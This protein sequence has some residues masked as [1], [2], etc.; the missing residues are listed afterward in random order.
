M[1]AVLAPAQPAGAA[2][3][4]LKASVV[5]DAATDTVTASIVGDAFTEGS[6]VTVHFD[7]IAGTYVSA[8]TQGHIPEKNTRVTKQATVSGGSLSVIGYQRAWPSASYRFYTE[9]VRVTVRDD[10]TGV[11]VQREGFCAYDTRTTYTFTCD[12]ATQTLRLV[13]AGGGYLAN[14]AI[15]VVYTQSYVSQYRPEDLRWGTTLPE[16]GYGVRVAADGS[17]SHVGYEARAGAT[18]PHYLYV[19]FGV[20][21]EQYYDGMPLVVGRGEASCLYNDGGR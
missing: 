12:Q 14:A 1:G 5:C 19:H 16:K 10:A 8:T 15:R 4:P 21:I 3:T 18:P 2:V 11:A 6:R 7:V 13:V 9:T 17:W 20:R